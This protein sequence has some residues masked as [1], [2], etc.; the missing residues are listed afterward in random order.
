MRAL[1]PCDYVI[2]VRS[3]RTSHVTSRRRL[4][5]AHTH[6]HWPRSQVQALAR[7]MWA[8]LNTVFTAT[9]S[10]LQAFF[11][12]YVFFPLPLLSFHCTRCWLSC[13]N[14]ISRTVSFPLPVCTNIMPVPFLGRLHLW[15]FFCFLSL[16]FTFVL[17][18]DKTTKTK[19]VR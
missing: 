15:V 5:E 17:Q 7:S 12:F 19:A 13:I 11:C 3:T 8:S 10:S 6:T 14:C 18:V 9:L 4:R 1:F 2:D 16:S